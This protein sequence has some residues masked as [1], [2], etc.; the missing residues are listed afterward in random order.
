MKGHPN[1]KE[2][3]AKHSSREESRKSS[4]TIVNN[5]FKKMN[6]SIPV[7]IPTKSLLLNSHRGSRPKVDPIKM[8]IQS[9]QL[10]AQ[11]SRYST[12]NLG[13]WAST[14]TLE[15]YQAEHITRSNTLRHPITIIA[16]RK[17]TTEAIPPSLRS[18]TRRSKTVSRLIYRNSKGMNL[19]SGWFLRV[20]RSTGT[21][22]TV[23]TLW[24]KAALVR[25]GVFA[26][27]RVRRSMQ[28]KRCIK[29]R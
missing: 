25:Y 9:Q 10:S 3:H 17:S 24:E 7:T 20:E 28:W 5:F 13:R 2:I 23:S 18:L 8:P 27:R 15:S 21:T 16:E 19:K 22:L 26:S 11:H 4:A 6:R 1:S 12:A 29:P 14:A